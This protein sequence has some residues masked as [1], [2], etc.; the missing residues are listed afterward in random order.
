MI[1]CCEKED[2]FSNIKLLLERLNDKHVY[3]ADL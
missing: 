1:A 2:F 3:Y